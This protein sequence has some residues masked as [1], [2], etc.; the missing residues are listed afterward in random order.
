[1]LASLLWPG[2]RTLWR[3][4]QPR[5]DAGALYVA[6]SDDCACARPIRSATCSRQ[7]SS[8][9][10]LLSRASTTVATKMPFRR[11][12]MD[13][14]AISD[15]TWRDQMKAS[16]EAENAGLRQAAGRRRLSWSAR[17]KLRPGRD[18]G[19]SEPRFF[20]HEAERAPARLILIDDENRLGQAEQPARRCH[21][22]VGLM[23]GK[24]SG[25]HDHADRQD[26][27]IVFPHR[28]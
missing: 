22:V 18:R 28:R 26:G 24:I 9:M 14:V 5:R 27:T 11:E 3:Q 1:M 16:G 10:T 19:G 12:G 4:V 6:I 15:P 2:S 13:A 21:L 8:P 25:R 23:A 20:G 7:R 17:P